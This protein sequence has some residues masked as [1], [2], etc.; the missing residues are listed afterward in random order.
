M[1]RRGLSTSPRRKGR[2]RRVSALSCLP[3]LSRFLLA[4][5]RPQASPT[6]RCKEEPRWARDDTADRGSWR[7]ELSSWVAGATSFSR[8]SLHASAPAGI[9]IGAW[10]DGGSFG[11]VGGG[12]G[13]NNG[14]DGGVP[15][16]DAMDEGGDSTDRAAHA[17]VCSSGGD[18]PSSA[19]ELRFLAPMKSPPFAPWMWLSAM[20]GL[21]AVW[22]RQSPLVTKA[23]T[24]GALALGGDMAAQFFEFRQ[25]AVDGKKT[26]FLKVRVAP[27]NFSVVG[28]AIW[29][30]FVV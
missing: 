14:T 7:T 26:P 6:M 22:L 3:S 29:R 20:W 23:L 27:H 9:G 8:S 17:Y 28:V 18:G 19:A 1:V 11:F 24:S 12:G 30:T 5:R 25:Q 21:Y 13:G 10:W 4:C 15:G 16:G 2:L